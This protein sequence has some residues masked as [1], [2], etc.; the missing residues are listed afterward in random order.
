[1]E[2]T[3]GD[4]TSDTIGPIIE[5]EKK[6]FAEPLIPSASLTHEKEQSSTLKKISLKKMKKSNRM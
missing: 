2:I 4:R 5:T 1:M 3:Y 6:T